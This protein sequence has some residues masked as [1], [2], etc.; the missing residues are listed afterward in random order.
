MYEDD[1]QQLLSLN[2]RIISDINVQ[3][4]GQNEQ[5]HF[6]TA[7]DSVDINAYRAYHQGIICG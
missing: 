5:A 6:T 4:F 3:L 2:A 7:S 1:M